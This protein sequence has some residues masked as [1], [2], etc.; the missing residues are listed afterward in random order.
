MMTPDDIIWWEQMR[1]RG[2]FQFVVREGIG[3]YGVRVG[4]A[5]TAIAAVFQF[6]F[7]G[8]PHGSVLVIAVLFPMMILLPGSCIGL[9]LWR[10]FERDY[11]RYAE[12]KPS[13]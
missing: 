12:H 2:A 6:L 8:D 4:V 1:A 5:V 9:V 13:A 3:H 10:Q 11:R 7:S